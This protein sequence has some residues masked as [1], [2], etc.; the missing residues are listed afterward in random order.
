MSAIAELGLNA[1]GFL[2]GM[3]SAREAVTSFQASAA[4]ASNTD[5]LPEGKVTKAALTI[6][7]AV[8]ALTAVL[9]KGTQMAIQFG[10]SLV[11]TSYNVGLG[12]AQTM[13]LQLAVERYG[14][15]ASA[16]VPA[17]QKFNSAL[18]DAANGT[19]PLVGVLKNAGISMESLAKMDVANRMAVVAQAIK[20]I[21]HPTEEAQTAVAV[22]GAEGVKMVE[23]FQPDKINSATAALGAQAGLMEQNAGIFAKI[24]QIMAQSGSTLAEI[25]SASKSKLQGFFV[26]MASELAPEILAV[27]ESLGKGT[28]SISDA[29]KQF[30]PALAPL[31]EIVDT[32][33]KMDFSKIGK[34]LGK[35]IKIAYATIKNVKIK[36]LLF[37]EGTMGAT[38]KT[39]AEAARGA[40]TGENTTEDLSMSFMDKLRAR[41]EKTKE[42]VA[43]GTASLIESATVK[44]DNAK[45]EIKALAEK[46]AQ[47][48]ATT[49]AQAQQQNATPP[50]KRVE[51]NIPKIEQPVA[52]V[53]EAINFDFVSSLARIGG[54]QFGPKADG[55]SMAVQIAR[56]QLEEQRKA[57]DRINETNLLLKIIS[58][59]RSSITYA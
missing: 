57:T 58:D 2:A 45:E 18:Q 11:D 13:A 56:Q 3:N 15:S 51:L 33:I 21:K 5:P 38:I 48:T 19:G 31:V 44:L 26:G 29:I 40:M 24:S 32:L 14:I 50:P 7:A 17:T 22:F 23:A 4:K 39:T 49:Q 28:T 1:S 53:T 43:D 35:E 8:V 10:S 41:W 36:D 20:G 25:T 37:G 34:D 42:V 46:A 12:A 54:S 55:G 16:V 30:A 9:A 27:L 47:T 52:K 6:T 59:Q